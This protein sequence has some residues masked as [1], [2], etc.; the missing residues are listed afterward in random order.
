[1]LQYLYN[2][3]E[4][5]AE[6]IV[7]VVAPALDETSKEEIAEAAA[8]QAE[9]ITDAVAD[10]SAAEGSEF[11]EEQY[12][13]MHATLAQVIYTSVMSELACQQACY[14]MED[15]F[16]EEAVED[17]YAAQEAEQEE[18]GEKW[19]KTKAHFKN[20]GRLYVGGASAAVGAAGGALIGRK[21]A[22]KKGIST[23]KGAIIGALVGGAAGVGVHELGRATS[24]AILGRKNAS[25][26]GGRIKHAFGGGRTLSY[27][28]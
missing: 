16:T 21:I 19:D 3:T 18:Y 13:A 4:A 14:A 25:G 12:D 26:F 24:R 8:D 9:A 6:E 20:N 27:R 5:A 17:F 15:L 23:K 2:E 10:A 1:M 28:G 22:A 7:E 11:T